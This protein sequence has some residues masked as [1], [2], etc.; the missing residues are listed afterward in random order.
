MTLPHVFLTFSLFPNV[1]FVLVISVFSFFSC[2]RFLRCPN[3]CRQKRNNCSHFCLCLLFMFPA[4]YFPGNERKTVFVFYFYDSDI[5]RLPEGYTYRH[6][7]ARFLFQLFIFFL[8]TENCHTRIFSTSFTSACRWLCYFP[9]SLQRWCSV[10]S[11]C[12]SDHDSIESYTQ[13]WGSLFWFLS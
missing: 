10:T 11:R 5:F 4:L 7:S 9:I 8:L 6:T 12:I 1:L 2:V 13:C 3:C